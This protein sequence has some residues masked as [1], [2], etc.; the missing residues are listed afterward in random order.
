MAESPKKPRKLKDLKARL[1]RT[2]VPN[3]GQGGAPQPG[4]PPQLGGPGGFVSPQGS[5]AG[6][7]GSVVPPPSLGSAAPPSMSVA[8]PPFLK[9][10]PARSGDP[11]SAASKAPEQREVR[12]VIDDKPVDDAEVGR[13]QRARTYLLIAGGLIV[14]MGVGGALG[15]TMSDRKVYNHTVQDGKD[16]YQSVRN[17]SGTVT[18]AQ[19]LIDRAVTAARGGPGQA[20]KVDYEAIESLRALEKPFVAGAFTRKQYMRFKATT[21]D[22]LFAYYN[23][24]NQLWDSY[25]GFAARTLPEQ[26]RKVLNASANAATAMATSPTGCVPM[27]VEGRLL[28]G[29]VYVEAA[30]P[31]GGKPVT[32]VMVK[33]TRKSRRAVEKTLYTGQDLSE[34]PENFVILTHTPRSVG[35]LGE[36]A[37]EFA[38]YQRDVLRLKKLVDEAIEM[39]GNLERELGEIAKLEEIFAF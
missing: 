23:K 17:A 26:R 7:G 29:L 10:K 11:F 15:S 19:Q 38:V 27:N 6:S 35:V 28:C 33:P 12:L 39:Q 22:T 14:G 30:P 18:N 16:V 2:I 37:T 36:Q 24:V 8:P 32:Q 13:Q 5:P 34:S 20:P 3:T 31:Q 9:P 4:G 21:V 25:D 1:G